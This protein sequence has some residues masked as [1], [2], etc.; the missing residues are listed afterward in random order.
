MRPIIGKYAVFSGVSYCFALLSV[1]GPAYY[2]YLDDELQYPDGPHFTAFF[3][4]TVLMV[5]GNVFG[6]LALIFYARFMKTWTFRFVLGIT[7]S[8]FYHYEFPQHYLV[9]QVE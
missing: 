7:Y 3:Y 2:F 6:I 5:C 1:A 8:D 4:N 9:C